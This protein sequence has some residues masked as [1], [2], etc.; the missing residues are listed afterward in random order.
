MKIARL[1]LSAARFAPDTPAGRFA[2]E[3]LAKAEAELQDLCSRPTLR[4]LE[5]IKF[6]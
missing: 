6:T 4:D 3:Q 2:R 5:P 1:K